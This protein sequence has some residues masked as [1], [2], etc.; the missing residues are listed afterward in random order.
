MSSC[1]AFASFEHSLLHFLR[2]PGGA[3]AHDFG[4][5]NDEQDL[6]LDVLQ[7]SLAS[8]TDVQQVA[9][10]PVADGSVERPPDNPLA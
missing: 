9:S 6:K 4:L 1:S 3:G 7:D 5:D 10:V 8:G 2:H